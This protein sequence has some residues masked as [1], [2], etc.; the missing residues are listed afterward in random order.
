MTYRQIISGR[1]KRR[2]RI[3][4][5]TARAFARMAAQGFGFSST[6]SADAVL[7]RLF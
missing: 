7:E 6:T 3:R 1:H 4:V 5:V 2:N